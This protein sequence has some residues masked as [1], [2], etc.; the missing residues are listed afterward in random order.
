MLDSGQHIKQ[1]LSPLR[2]RKRLTRFLLKGMT[3]SSDASPNSSPEFLHDESSVVTLTTLPTSPLSA[4]L[5]SSSESVK[6]SVTFSRIA[7]T[8]DTDIISKICICFQDV[9]VCTSLEP[10]P[11]PQLVK[12]EP[13]VCKDHTCVCFKQICK[14]ATPLCVCCTI[15]ENSVQGT[16]VKRHSYRPLVSLDTVDEEKDP[17]GVVADA[18]NVETLSSIIV[19]LEDRVDP[20][21][22][23]KNDKEPPGLHK[24]PEGSSSKPSEVSPTHF[25]S[26]RDAIKK[27]LEKSYKYKLK[28]QFKIHSLRRTKTSSLSWFKRRRDNLQAIPIP[29]ANMAL[30]RHYDIV[31][32]LLDELDKRKSHEQYLSRQKALDY[33]RVSYVKAVIMRAKMKYPSFQ[34]RKT[35]AKT[36]KLKV[37]SNEKSSPRKRSPIIVGDY[38][39]FQSSTSHSVGLSPIEKSDNEKLAR[40]LVRFSGKD[41][42]FATT[43]TCSFKLSVS[44]QGQEK[45]SSTQVEQPA[46]HL[47]SIPSSVTVPHKEPTP[48]KRRDSKKQN[49]QDAITLIDDYA[50]EMGLHL[51]TPE[52]KVRVDV[53]GEHST[54]SSL[55]RLNKMKESEPK[56]KSEELDIPEP[57][58]YSG[59]RNRTTFTSVETKSVMAVRKLCVGE[60]SIATIFHDCIERID[61]VPETHSTLS[62]ASDRMKYEASSETSKQEINSTLKTGPMGSATIS[63]VRGLLHCEGSTAKGAGMVHQ[64]SSVLVKK[65]HEATTSHSV[66]SYKNSLPPAKK[67]LQE[68]SASN[69]SSSAHHRLGTKPQGPVSHIVKR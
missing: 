67:V 50:Q 30:R 45:L 18:N 26:L 12:L 7:N 34:H 36:A 61:K 31:P 6:P 65:A 57:G 49:G 25:S 55:R 52:S 69:K 15:D 40:L 35:L 41:R 4:A 23:D 37:A 27:G 39:A 63:Q 17:R 59:C 1:P 43:E 29:E 53:A 22:E 21:P 3:M 20:A 51:T 10:E 28:I 68:S 60:R 54:V 24:E 11:R 9:C 38:D 47:P 42:S 44:N 62:V 66:N 2:V 8:N 64:K 13:R 46:T 19:P 48:S 5:S 56:L 58:P 32:G 33:K 14:C 16:H